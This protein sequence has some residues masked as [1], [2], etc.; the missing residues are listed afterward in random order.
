[1][2]SSSN[3]DYDV[4]EE[5]AMAIA[6]LNRLVDEAVHGFSSEDSDVERELHRA[7]SSEEERESLIAMYAD[8]QLLDSPV[9]LNNS[10]VSIS[11]SDIVQIDETDSE[12][13]FR[14][15]GSIDSDEVDGYMDYVYGQLQLLRYV[16]VTS[17]SPIDMTN[18]LAV[19]IRDYV[20]TNF[21][22]FRSM[23]IEYREERDIYLPIIRVLS[24]GTERVMDMRMRNEIDN[25][26][27]VSSSLSAR[28]SRL[29]EVDSGYLELLPLLRSYLNVSRRRS[30]NILNRLMYRE[31]GS[32]N[33]SSSDRIVWCGCFRLLLIRGYMRVHVS[34]CR[35]CNMHY[36]P[37]RYRVLCGE[38]QNVV[39]SL[40]SIL[41]V[42]DS[43]NEYCS[44][45]RLL[46]LH[47]RYEC[48]Y[49][50]SSCVYINREW[51]RPMCYHEHIYILLNDPRAYFNDVHREL[52]RFIYWHE[53][54]SF[55][56]S[57]SLDREIE[58]ILRMRNWYEYRVQN[59][60]ASSLFDAVYGSDTSGSGRMSE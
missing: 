34:D 43:F 20:Y 33:S 24:L 7:L 8:E 36:C 16:S 31:N 32:S 42:S 44:V 26:L 55:D 45:H 11:D 53:N 38:A 4:D 21:N 51:G 58:R 25:V 15:S 13:G 30:N 47:P 6:D 57:T 40:L 28:V 50:A 49:E 41:R 60:Y 10:P 23:M 9:L 1:M 22:A 52:S 27:Y 3:N 14:V 48:L 12:N 5:R 2:D 29:L 59:V 56:N 17:Y 35:I 54:R 39:R 18:P 46:E 37:Y 19:R